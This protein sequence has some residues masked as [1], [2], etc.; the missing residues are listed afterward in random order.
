MAAKRSVILYI[1]TSLDG[2][3]AGPNG[4]LEWLYENDGYGYEEFYAGVDTLVM[5]K[6][7][8]V[9]VLGMVDEYPYPGKTV[10]V[11]S[12]TKQG[13]DEN[14]AIWTDATPEELLAMIR[15]E[16]G[17][18]IW[19]AG[20]GE[21]VAAWCAAN[22][23]DEYLIF[24]HPIVLGDGVPLFPKSSIRTDLVLRDTFAYEDGLVRLTYDRKG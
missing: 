3:I 12:R 22:L 18:N 4:E 17:K 24:V 13:T 19:M 15:K 9:D 2:Y 11:S 10:Y 21:I 6:K 8:Y 20:G 16:E 7:T 23:I 5:G 1:A 14:G